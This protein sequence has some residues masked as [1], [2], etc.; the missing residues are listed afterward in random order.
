MRPPR[1]LKRSLLLLVPASVMA[2]LTQAALAE[3][4]RRSAESVEQ[5]LLRIS[6]FLKPIPDAQWNQIAGA[7]ISEQ[8]TITPGDTLYDISR[9]L[10]GDPGYWPK[11]WALNNSSITNPHLIRPGNR[12]SFLPGTGTELPAVQIAQAPSASSAAEP[13]HAYPPDSAFMSDA[14][15]ARHDAGQGPAPTVVDEEGPVEEG[16]QAEEEEEREEKAPPRDFRGKKRSA[17][18]RK[19]P[20]QRWEKLVMKSMRK[21]TDIGLGFE[22]KDRIKNIQGIT[23]ELT[24]IAA[25]QPIETLGEIIA[26]QAGATY[27]SPPNTVYIKA[28]APLELNKVYAITRAPTEFSSDDDSKTGYSYNLLG[29]VRIIQG[30]GEYYVGRIT[31]GK[32]WFARGSELIPVPERYPVLSP[33]PGQTPLE[34]KILVDHAFSTFTV[35]QFKQVFLDRGSADGVVPGNVFKVY[36]STDFAT[37][38][39][40]PNQ[41]WVE[42]GSLMVVQVSE[43]YS[44]AI[45]ISSAMPFSEGM[46]ATRYTELPPDQAIPPLVP[47][48]EEDE[49]D[50]LTGPEEL[51]PEEEATLKQLEK[52]K[53]NPP[54]SPAPAPEASPAPSPELPPPPGEPAPELPPPSEPPA[55]PLTEPSPSPT[56]EGELPP[57]DTAPIPEPEPVPP[58]P[59]GTNPET[60]PA[61]EPA[62]VPEAAPEATPTPSPT[63]TESPPPSESQEIDQ[64]LGQ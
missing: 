38:L 13:A 32:T 6:R 7:R 34:A 14:E 15:L 47:K 31:D 64:L 48:A 24:A 21:R 40:V 60:A 33:V 62:P 39:D 58:P 26:S 46:I 18:W 41:K 30:N 20:L 23:Y 1:S 22:V 12:V 57:P 35:A 19:M 25:S 4:P 29:R 5:E 59:D 28:K 63:S 42:D 8:Y 11:I 17:E 51:T 9:R 36:Q 54:S 16:E 3:I 2:A 27:L 49:L 10:F 53:G 61:L 56:A 50:L 52:W 37:G 44:A 55:E 45:V 43:H